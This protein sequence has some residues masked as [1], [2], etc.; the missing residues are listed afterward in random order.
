MADPLELLAAKDP[1]AVVAN[2]LDRITEQLSS[3][4]QATASTAVC[5]LT[6]LSSHPPE[7]G[8]SEALLKKGIIELVRQRL[9]FATDS[10]AL[11]IV[12]LIHNLADTHVNRLRILSSGALSSL[13]RV[14]LEPSAPPMLKERAVEAAA[15]VADA[16][17]ES[18]SFPQLIGRLCASPLLGTQGEALKSLALLIDRKELREQ[19]RHVPEIVSGLAA[20]VESKASTNRDVAR[21][22]SQTL[23]L[24]CP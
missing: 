20:A 16:G 1:Q 9:N 11:Q 8:I 10:L 18:I 13:T 24:P 22:L 21:Q 17:Q 15:S 14:I 4:N 19:L 2:S 7:R 6:A 12:N 5:V 3:P 23:L